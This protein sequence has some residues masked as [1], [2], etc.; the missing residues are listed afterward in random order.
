MPIHIWRREMRKVVLG[1]NLTLDG[2]MGGPDGEL[3][4]MFPQFTEGYI[5]STS[6][7]LAEV[8]TFLMGRVAYEGMASYWPNATDEIAPIMNN[9]VKY[10]F[11]T[12]LADAEWNNARLTTRDPADLIAELKGQGGKNIGIAGGSM[13][14]QQIV[15]AGLIDEYR[16]AIHPVA[17]GEGLRLFVGRCSL[18]MIHSEIFDGG[19]V[20]N[21]YLRPDR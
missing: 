12:T 3:D 1:M 11:S 7:T 6:Q 19:L 18:T 17:L 13:F 2:Y 5:L 4:W 8:D 10:V 9:T 16:L 20:V 15:R 14:A 21:T